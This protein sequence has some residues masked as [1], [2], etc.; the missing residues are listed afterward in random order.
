MEHTCV[1]V[2]T[3][4]HTHSYLILKQIH[5]SSS[6]QSQVT[7][8]CLH[9]LQEQ[10]IKTQ[11]ARHLLPL[12]P[13]ILPCFFQPLPFP[14]FSP[15]RLLSFSPFLF[16]VSFVATVIFFLP[17]FNSLGAP[18]QTECECCVSQPLST[19]LTHTAHINRRAV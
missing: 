8:G 10:Y 11:R 2:H 5:N 3:E 7:T 19:H 13:R 1:H 4:T 6:C 16:A 15:Y 14:A 18:I 17:S 12:S 9:L